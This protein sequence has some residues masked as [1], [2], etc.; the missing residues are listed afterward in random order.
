[1]GRVIEAVGEGVRLRVR[2]EGPFQSLVRAVIGQQ[3]SG[4]AAAT[5]FGRFKSLYPGSVFPSPEEVRVTHVNRLRSA[6]LSGSKAAYVKDIAR[7]VIGGLVPTPAEC[8]GL[9]DS[10]IID[11]LTQV[12]GI[13][14]WTAEMFLMFNLGRPDV[15]PSHDLGIRKGF[16]M[17]FKKRGLPDPKQVDRHGEIWR[18]HRSTA[19]LYLWRAIDFVDAGGSL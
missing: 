6:G 10:E 18:P 1:M 2:D 3:L 14:R 12:R 17:V 4:K 11:R 5:I 19:A 16:Q 8:D 13:G 7:Q 15:L 9:E